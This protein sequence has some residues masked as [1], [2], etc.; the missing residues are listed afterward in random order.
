MKNLRTYGQKPYRVAVIHGGPGAPGEV[1]PVARELARD[2][3]V[4]EPLQT[5]DTVGGQIE[6]LREV[7]TANADPPVT[8]VGFSWGAWLSYLYTSRYPSSVRKLI[9]IGTPPFPA[10]MAM[11]V[12]TTRLERMSEAERA[13]FFAL[14]EALNQPG[15]PDRNRLMA[16]F[17]A[18]TNRADAYELLPYQSELIEYLFDIN[19]SVW[20]EANRMRN[21]GE[22]LEAGRAIACP[23]VAIHGDH[24]P[25]PVAGVRE[26]LAGILQDFSFVLLEKCGHEPWLERYARDEFFRVLREEIG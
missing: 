15:N 26:P 2:Y 24:D 23:V 12:M 10:E 9:L 20:A 5:K 1:A 7:L 6:E 3:G 14:T 8:L 17:A 18:L 25:H 22:L 4:L 13:E 11:D 19:Q 16:R 21:S